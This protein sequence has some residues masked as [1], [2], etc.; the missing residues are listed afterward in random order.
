M[1]TKRGR[2]FLRSLL[3]SV[4]ILLFPSILMNVV[5]FRYFVEVSERQVSATT[6]RRLDNISRE[7]AGVLTETQGMALQL[8]SDP[9]LTPYNLLTSPL[10][11]MVAI[12][13][14]ATLEASNV[15]LRRVGLWIW[16]SPH[17]L[18]ND[19]AY[20]LDRV[21]EAI[22]GRSSPDE[23]PFP[24]RLLEHR[25][26]SV[27]MNRASDQA[28][29]RL[30][31][32]NHPLPV[33]S[34][35]PFGTVIFFIGRGDLEDVLREWSAANAED[36]TIYDRSGTV[37]AHHGPE[38][39][40]DTEAITQQRRVEAYGWT[41]VSRQSRAVIRRDIHEFRWILVFSNAIIL[42]LGSAIVFW[43]ASVNYRPIVRLRTRADRLLAN[44]GRG[45]IGNEFEGIESALSAVTDQNAALHAALEDSLP[46][47]RGQLLLNVFKGQV[48]DAATIDRVARTLG[49]ELDG[50]V[51]GVACVSIAGRDQQRSV[52][53]L[54]DKQVL[55]GLRW[56][57]RETL[58]GDASAFLLVGDGWCPESLITAVC[59]TVLASPGLH[60]ATI[61]IGLPAS[62]LA[63][64]AEAFVQATRAVDYRFTR[65]GG[66]IYLYSRHGDELSLSAEYPDEIIEEILLHTRTGDPD[67]V[68]SACSRANE[69]FKRTALP[70]GIVRCVTFEI[71]TGIL[72]LIRESDRDLLED[73]VV[74]PDELFGAGPDSIRRQFGAV[75]EF[76]LEL[77]AVLK[78][79]K[80]SHNGA[81]ATEMIRY[82]RA[83]AGRLDFSVAQMAEHFDLCPSYISRYFK[84]QVGSTITH[85]VQDLRMEEAKRLLL[86]SDRPIHEIVVSVG[87]FDTSSFI[88]KFRS[89]IGLTPGQ[90][91]KL[92]RDANR[93]ESPTI[94][95]G[96][97]ETPVRGG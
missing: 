44:A 11:Q 28:S 92:H 35:Y 2:Y 9:A 57:G 95:A 59:D 51:Y 13:R 31:M 43:L 71:L 68:R 1:R 53:E 19:G 36:L 61:G 48:S 58:A 41:V 70:D 18:T 75:T 24:S 84:D 42:S 3:S 97:D 45:S 52:L 60:N 82:L 23:Q 39:P 7:L 67:G 90:Y 54:L 27:L 25:T 5:A 30:V 20:R 85:F 77:S 14:L 62:S 93:S 22:L 21:A 65:G 88:K 66:T 96:E 49:L 38:L 46:A 87:Y 50:S 78:R 73:G 64:V 37:V 10:A 69:R 47:R 94:P 34:P 80:E 29:E 91:R 56:Y 32:I 8:G 72:R 26:F 81:L 86:K 83:N 15:I 4:L 12:D 79:A 6:A 40:P 16:G 33:G 76:A 17:L 55:G 63:G 89:E 74:P